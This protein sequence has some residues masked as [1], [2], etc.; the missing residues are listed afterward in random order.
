MI[1]N[2]SGTFGNTIENEEIGHKKNFLK[3]EGS[4]VIEILDYRGIV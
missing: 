2:S 1:E 4:L 3:A